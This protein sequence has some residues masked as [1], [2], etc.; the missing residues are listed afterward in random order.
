[1]DLGEGRNVAQLFVAAAHAEPLSWTLALAPS[2]LLC[3]RLEDSAEAFIFEILEAKFQRV[4]LDRMSEL[5]HVR[6][7][8]KVIRCRCQC[9]VRSLAQRRLY[10][11]KDDSLIRNIVVG[12][13]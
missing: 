3:R 13:N 6:L 9:P 12:A 10:L 7:A 4:H 2:K 11:M 8:R 1:M 5:V